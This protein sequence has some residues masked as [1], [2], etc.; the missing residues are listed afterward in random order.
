MRLLTGYNLTLAFTLLG[1]IILV[2]YKWQEK[3]QFLKITLWMLVPLLVLTL[4]LGYLDELRDYYEV[5]PAVI[6][7]ISHSIARVLGIK[8]EVH[9]G[10]KIP[11]E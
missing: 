11:E 2:Y 7:L 1:L 3:P 4:C 6:I 5:Y 10:N 8:L 9:R